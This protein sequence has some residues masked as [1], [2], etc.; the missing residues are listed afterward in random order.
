MPPSGRIVD[1][2]DTLAHG[3]VVLDH[4]TAPGTAVGRST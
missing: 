3:S 4:P 1:G 2:P